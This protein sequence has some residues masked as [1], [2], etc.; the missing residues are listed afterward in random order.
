MQFTIFAPNYT[1]KSGGAWVLHFLCHSL[2]Q[3]GFESSI[4]IYQEEQRVNPNFNTPIGYIKDSIV[5]Y[6]EIVVDNPLNAKNVARYLLN[7]E[8]HLQGR[9][10]NWGEGDYPLSFSRVYRDDCDVLF[11]PN[12]DLSVFYKDDTLKT[13]NAYYVG[14]GSLYG[15]CPPLDCFEIT[16]SF[17]ETKQELGNVLRRSKILFSYDAVSATNTDAALCGCLPYL[18]QKPLLGTDKAELGKYWA[19]S[20][21]EIDDAL[22]QMSTLWDRVDAL[23]KTFP[24]RLGNQAT[25]I[26]RHFT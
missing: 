25:K 11:Y 20:E 13:Q 17:P 15:E 4:F 18:L 14:K 19:E 21:E 26:V 8:G 1:D 23:Q 6:P 12:C 24:E 22:E 7:K 16:R 10:I 3:I 9:N 5:I 2:N